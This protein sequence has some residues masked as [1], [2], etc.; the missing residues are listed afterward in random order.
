MLHRFYLSIFDNLLQPNK[1]LVIY[2]PRQIGKTTLVREYLRRTSFKYRFHTGD[3][4][5][6]QNLLGSRDL[7]AL[8]EFAEGQ[9]LLIIDEA[10][11]IP[12]VG[13]GLKMLVDH[14]DG[15][16][17]IATGSA[18]FDLSGKIGEPLTGRKTTRILYSLAQMELLA[19]SEKFDLRSSLD[20]FLLYGS[21]PE[22]LTSTSKAAKKEC[23][24]ELVG[25]Y[26]LK[27]ILELERVK[28]PRHLLDLLKLLAFQI[29]RDV[30]LSELASNLGID[31]K[32][33]ARYLDLLEKSFV[34]VTLSG[35]SRN[36]R[37][38]I[39]KSRR[40]F[41]FDNGIRNAVISNFN[42]LDLRD[43]VGALWENF[44]VMERLKKSHYERSFKNFYFWRTYD[45]K[46]I[47]LVEEA[48]GKL[49]GFELKY[50]KRAVKKPEEFL[51][52]YPGSTF[53]VIHR[54][55]YLDFVT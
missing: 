48:D 44:V 10:Q 47:D 37:K 28:N 50:S 1:V 21:Y 16:R 3:D 27:D 23:L 49:A 2:G 36:L 39:S 7:K 26:L 11:R 9:Q 46:E 45:Q 38:E 30:S 43:D 54:Q 18:S 20:G 4:L 8:Q 15:L 22:V 42:S 25:S 35:F 40:Y 33:V 29:G 53:E 13:L 24:H 19:E 34:I 55:N 51:S 5:R 17:I 14:V 12:D 52:T 6:V 32:T 41:F 31:A